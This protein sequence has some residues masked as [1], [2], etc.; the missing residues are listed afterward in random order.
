VSGPDA[1]HLPDSIEY[2][3]SPRYYHENHI[4]ERLENSNADFKHKKLKIFYYKIMNRNGLIRMAFAAV[5]FILCSGV[6]HAQPANS[7]DAPAEKDG[8][9]S[10]M[11]Y[12]GMRMMMNSRRFY[13]RE[14][15]TEPTSAGGLSVDIRFNVPI[16]PRTVLPEFIQINGMQL[17]S[18]TH[19]AFN[20]AGSVLRFRLAPSVCT[21]LIKDGIRAFSLDLT[22]AAS[23]NGTELAGKHFEITGSKYSSDFDEPCNGVQD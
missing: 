14:I 5:L 6:F 7:T 1:L 2:T 17:S 22:E 19:V 20:K 8:C 13:V 23:F 18:D 10:V 4:G 15:R 12:H 16:D 9:F 21:G 11:P 3:A